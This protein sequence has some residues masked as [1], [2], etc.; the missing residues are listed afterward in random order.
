[1]FIMYIKLNKFVM[2]IKVNKFIMYIVVI[3]E[4]LSVHSLLCT[5]RLLC[6]R[7]AYVRVEH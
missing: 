6:L 1:M 3:M 2:Y 7:N 4:S 5:L